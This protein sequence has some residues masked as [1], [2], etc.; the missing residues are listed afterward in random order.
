M[1][2]GL[3]PAA[4]GGNRTGRVFTGDS[5]GDWLFASLHRVGLATQATS[6]HA[7]DG[8]ALV[9]A[10]MVA[11]VRCAPPANKPTPVERDTCAPWL[12]RELALVAPTMRVVVDPRRLRLGRGAEG[13]RPRGARRTH[14][15][16]A[17]RPRRRGG[18]RRAHRARLLPPQPAQHVH[19][20]AHPRHARCRLHPGAVADRLVTAPVSQP[21]E[22][23]AL[24][25]VQCGFDPHRGHP[26]EVTNRRA[27][28]LTGHA[29][30]RS[31]SS[32]PRRAAL[33][34]LRRRAARPSARTP[35]QLRREGR[36]LVDPQ[37][38]VVI[39]HGLNLVWKHAPYVPPA[40]KAGFLARDA[41]WLAR[42]GF[43]GAR[44]GTL[45]AGLTPDEAGV[46][47][48]AY[49][50]KW[51]RVMDLLAD[52]RIWMMLDAHQDQ[53]HETYGGEG[54][55][56]WAMIRPAP[57]D[58]APPVVAP[59]PHRLLDAGGLDRLRQL[60]GRPGRPAHRLGRRL[61]GRRAAVEAAALP[62]GLR[63]A[64]RAVDGP[65]VGDLPGERV[66]AVLPR[67]APARD[68]PRPPRHPRD[69]PAQPGLVGAAAVRRRPE[70]RHVLRGGARREAARALVAQLLPGRVPRVP[71]RPGRRRRELL[72]VQPRPQP[73]RPRRSPARCAPRR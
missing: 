56:D 30:P 14:A 18:A 19:R 62:D 25:A 34:E 4:N 2:V 55:P 23:A 12:D 68:G 27:P 6:V 53:W 41:R 47:D 32:L 40:T 33:G 5:S 22:E 31:G 61:E 13:A 3:A 46:E 10:R 21:A 15:A 71:G 42:H 29:S 50:A 51:Q 52:R 64:Q 39:V 59:F 43:N 7:G 9:D 11:T 20:P 58:A 24:K 72:G 45:W 70:A 8:Q 60:L 44:I 16:A 37:G 1:I 54:V 36:W 49:A 69:R 38:R 35:P 17:V 57:Y 48:P 67:R 26:R 73:A 66:P 65:G 63:P 28:S